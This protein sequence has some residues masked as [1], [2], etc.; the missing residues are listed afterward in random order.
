MEELNDE[1][2]EYNRKALETV[3]TVQDLILEAIK[4]RMDL[5]ERML[6][7]RIDME[8]ELMDILTERYE[9]ERDQTIELAELKKETLE[10]EIDLVDELLEQRR[11]AAEE[12]DRAAKIEELEAQLARISA[13]QKGRTGIARGN[14]RP[15]RR[16]GMG[17]C[18]GR[19]GSAEGIAGRT[20]RQH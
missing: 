12:E 14:Q 1:I 6:E 10:D 7:G 4:D 20:D 16:D 5:E 9:K 19:S 17:N 2:E 13:A 3:T 15:A 11:K 18:G 8:E